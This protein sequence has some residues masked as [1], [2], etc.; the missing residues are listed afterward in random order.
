M[1]D[2]DAAEL[3]KALAEQRPGLAKTDA[4]DDEQDSQAN[5]TAKLGA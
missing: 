4:S 2:E 1:S 5:A 3:T